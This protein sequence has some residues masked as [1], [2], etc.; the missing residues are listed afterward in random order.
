MADAGPGVLEFVVNS[1]KNRAAHYR[2]RAAHLR[3][4]AEGEPFGRLRENLIGLADQFD[5]LAES[6]MIRPSVA[7][8]HAQGPTPHP[9]PGT[10]PVMPPDPSRPPPI[11]EPPA[12]IPVPRPESPP[13]PVDDP[14]PRPAALVFAAFLLISSSAWAQT[15]Q[16]IPAGLWQFMSQGDMPTLPSSSQAEI[17]SSFTNCIDPARTVPVNPRFSCQVSDMNRNGAAV[18]WATTCTTQYGTFRSQGVAQ[19]SGDTMAGTLT[20]YVPMIGGEVRQ[21]ISGRFLGPCQR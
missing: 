9:P 10:P 2:E 17:S 21:R 3:S 7:A 1:V 6:L 12:P 11:T 16:T 18:T 19:Y 15:P 8:T 20:T 4:L 5:E 14:P 13:A